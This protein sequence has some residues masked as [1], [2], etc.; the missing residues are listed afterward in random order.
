LSVFY[1][2]SPLRNVPSFR[3]DD[4]T[5]LLSLAWGL[6]S[7]SIVSFGKEKNLIKKKT[8]V[9]GLLMELAVIVLCNM[10]MFYAGNVFVGKEAP[11]REEISVLRFVFS[12]LYSLSVVISFAFAE[13]VTLQSRGEEE[14]GGRNLT[15][16]EIVTQLAMYG[17]NV[18][19]LVVSESC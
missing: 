5:L 19:F 2:W 1:D 9:I 6:L 4:P 7:V 3:I 14:G 12:L 18:V 17:A 16:K 15:R 10:V 11:K 13:Y 8:D